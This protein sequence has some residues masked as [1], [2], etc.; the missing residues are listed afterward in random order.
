MRRWHFRRFASLISLFVAL[1]LVCLPLLVTPRPARAANIVVNST[2]DNGPGNCTTICT[3]R[4]AIA[5]ANAG[6]NI[7][8]DYPS[9]FSTP[10]TITLTGGPLTINK[11]VYIWGPG[12]DA[13]FLTID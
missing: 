7:A 13:T 2:A 1:T 6:D 4:D 11:N 3:L 12:P 9:T 10:Q 5:T 8:F